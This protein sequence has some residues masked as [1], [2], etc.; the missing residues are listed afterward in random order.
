MRDSIRNEIKTLLSPHTSSDDLE[1]AITGIR[2][3]LAS[4]KNEIKSFSVYLQEITNDSAVVM[5]IYFTRFPM[6]FDNLNTLK[7]EI[8]LAIKKLQEKHE[9]KPS[10][11][12]SVK[13]VS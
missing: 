12:G 11:P 6:T 5:V 7:E 1:K 3:I 13:L 8:N 2:D 9:I 4:K 10:S